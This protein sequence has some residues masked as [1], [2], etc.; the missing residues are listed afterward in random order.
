LRC[1]SGAL[2]PGFQLGNFGNTGFGLIKLP[3]IKIDQCVGSVCKRLE[4]ESDPV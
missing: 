4:Y 2:K 1:S 3:E